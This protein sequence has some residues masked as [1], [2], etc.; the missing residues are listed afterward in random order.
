MML[1]KHLS[2]FLFCSRI[3]KMFTKVLFLVLIFNLAYSAPETSK[4]IRQQLLAQTANNL[5]TS[6]DS[7]DS[8]LP[9][10]TPVPNEQIPIYTSPFPDSTLTHPRDSP[11]W[12]QPT[13]PTD[14][15]SR[16]FWQ[17]SGQQI[18]KETL[19]K[20]MNKKVAK[21]LIILV[22]DGMSI[23]TQMATRMYKGGEEEVLSFEKF[24]YVGLSKVR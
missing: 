18:L 4:F 10:L 13:G 19:Q 22:A 1:E 23:P 6:T 15:K 8:N 3:D 24:P 17:S 2:Q 5:E 9:I 21:N 16:E 14:E 7:R 12:T 11:E 20:E